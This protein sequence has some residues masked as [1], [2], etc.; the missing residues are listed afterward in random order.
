MTLLTTLLSDVNGGGGGTVPDGTYIFKGS[1]AAPEDFPTL[2]EVKNGWIYKINADVVFDNDPLK[3]NTGLLFLGRPYIKWNG[4]TW[5]REGNVVSTG[6][7]Y[8]YLAIFD[9]TSYPLLYSDSNVRIDPGTNQ[10]YTLGANFANT[11]YFVNGQVI[12][13]D[14]NSTFTTD[15]MYINPTVTGA[16]TRVTQLAGNLIS[17]LSPSPAYPLI[18]QLITTSMT[19]AR[20]LTYCASQVVVPNFIVQSG[21]TVTNLYGVYIQ[22]GQY[23]GSGT[24]TNGYGLY[25]AQPAFGTSK[26]AIGADS[27]RVNGDAVVT[28]DLGVGTTS[29][30]RLV[31][32]YSGAE[33]STSYL[34]ISAGLDGGPSTGNVSMLELVTRGAG[35]GTITNSIQSHFASDYDIKATSV[36]GFSVYTASSVLA[37]YTDASQNF[38]A[39]GNIIAGTLGKGFCFTGGTNAKIGTATLVAGVV[40]VAN[41]SITANSFI[42]PVGVGSSANAGAVWPES[43]TVGVGFVLRSDNPLDDRDVTY[44]IFERV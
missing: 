27:L 8:G 44:V 31:D 9:G 21:F 24:A 35:G 38:T 14:I 5:D 19:A 33:A 29:P 13:S 23:S 37:T 3:T 42:H 22:A 36:G 30:A 26:Y 28:G 20:S 1:I 7:S 25:V 10:I 32:V 4:T 2:A 15:Y 43:Q 18:G 17:P 6:G 41:T 39:Y 34:R 16:F 12:L 11:S 40:T